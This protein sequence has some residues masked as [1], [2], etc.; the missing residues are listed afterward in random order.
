MIQKNPNIVYLTAKIAGYIL[1]YK[2]VPTRDNGCILEVYYSASGSGKTVELA[3][4]NVTRDSHL[5]LLVT[6]ARDITYQDIED[7]LSGEGENLKDEEKK[8][9]KRN[10]LA[11]GLLRDAIDNLVGEGMGEFLL[12]LK[13]PT[14]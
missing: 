11:F 9:D 4:S 7:A 13:C 8:K 14:R 6:L 10:E 3:V 5:A 2:T 1:V 12:H